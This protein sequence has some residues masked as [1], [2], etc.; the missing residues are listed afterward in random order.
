MCN[1]SGVHFI[2]IK[3]NMLDLNPS[4]VIVEIVNCLFLS[5][6]TTDI[7]DI[8]VVLIVRFW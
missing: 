7:L 4:E 3:T 2:S 8:W 5:Q 1:S 6:H